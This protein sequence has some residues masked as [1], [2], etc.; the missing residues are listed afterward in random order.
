MD[1]KVSIPVRQGRSNATDVSPGPWLWL[2]HH[3]RFKKILLVYHVINHF[4]CT[5]KTFP[6]LFDTLFVIIVS[7]VIPG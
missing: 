4:T 6:A 3:D 7:S 5:F 2:Y 1:Q